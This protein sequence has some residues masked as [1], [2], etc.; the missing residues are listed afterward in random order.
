MP[1]TTH[2]FTERAIAP[3]GRVDKATG[4]IHDVRIIGTRSRNR[5]T[6][7]HDAL[8]SAVGKY[9]GVHVNVNH[10]KSSELHEDRQFDDWAGVLR[11]VVYRE[12]ALYG[13]LHLRRSSRWFDQIV[14][15]ATDFP[16]SF[17][18]SHV[19]DGDSRMDAGEEI[20]ESID[21]VFS[22]DIVLN[23]ATNSGLFESDGRSIGAPMDSASLVASCDGIVQCVTKI[24]A[25][26]AETT[27]LP[28]G[29]AEGL[30]DLAATAGA[31][32]LREKQSSS[33]R[34][35]STQRQ[36]SRQPLRD[37]VL[38]YDFS[39]PGAFANRYR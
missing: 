35:E 14:E 11:N 3:I 38:D 7:T 23:P 2:R 4:V 19:A 37:E 15:A 27:P 22:V 5:R 36:A 1:A 31:I 17:G 12:G 8:Q 20:V 25:L 24:I 39:S 34:L 30:L 13:D 9:E 28:E 32:A 21:S 10:P 26:S 6:Y 18:L 16:N 29:I 33:T